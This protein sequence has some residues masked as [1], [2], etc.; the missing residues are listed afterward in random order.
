MPFTLIAI[1]LSQIYT[2]TYLFYH[3]KM[4]LITEAVKPSVMVNFEVIAQ[5]GALNSQ[6]EFYKRINELKTAQNFMNTVIV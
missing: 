5:T 4:K 1:C 3:S 2:F 6:D